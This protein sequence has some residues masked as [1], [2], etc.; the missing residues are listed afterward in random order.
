MTELKRIDGKH[1][2]CAGGEAVARIVGM[3]GATDAFEKLEDGVWIWRRHTDAPVDRMRME[4][5]FFGKP[6]FTMVPAVSYNGNGWGSVPEYVGDRDEDGTPWSF[7]SHRCTVPAC[8]YS[9]NKAASVALMSLPNDNTACSLYLTDEGEKHVVIF[10]EEEQPRTLQRHFWKEGFQGTMAPRQDFTA[11]L[12][13]AEGDGTRFRY[14]TLLDVAWRLYA[15]PLTPPMPAAELYRLS[16]AFC[17]YLY[18]YEPDGF[19]AFSTGAQWHKAGS[20]FRK[21]SHRFQLGWVGQN[22]SMAAAFLYDYLKTGDKAHLEMAMETDDAWIR[23]CTWKKGLLASRL[24]RGKERFIVDGNCE[25]DPWEWGNDSYETLSNRLRNIRAGK[26]PRL[27]ADGGV[28]IRADA[29]NLGTGAD[30]YFEAY[31]LL[32][33][34]GIDKPEYLQ[35]ALDVCAFAMENQNENGSFAAAWDE[36]GKLLVKDGTIGCFLVLPLLTAY[37]MTGESK[38]LDSAKRAFDFYCGELEQNGYTTAGALDTYSI[39]KESASPL[40]RAA[41]RLYDVTQGRAYIA[42]AERI[43][44]YLCTWM[45]HFTVH[46]PPDCMISEMGFDTFGATAV[47]TPHNALDQYALRDVLSFLK[48]AELTGFAQWRERALAMWC[49]ANQGISDGTLY[50]NRRLRPAGSQDEAVF[51]TR[52]GRYISPAFSVSQWLPAWPCAFRL[53]DLRWHPDWSLFDEGLTRIEGKLPLPE[54]DCV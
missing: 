51:H 40:L 36:D 23:F 42:A 7:A 19:A 29:C 43:G 37:R 20:S 21:H 18:T 15:H 49:A 16:I 52:W 9:E 6:D 4:L 27:A 2:I 11:I 50:L 33:Q 1:L 28:A 13:A 8:T 53:E 34:A 41:L 10:P 26:M 48:L 17:R 25:L 54:S 45:M 44:W 35:T 22:A 24:D 5:L 46:Y 31:E 47:S 12:H 3:D 39:D 14:R 32:Q 30:G 38:Y